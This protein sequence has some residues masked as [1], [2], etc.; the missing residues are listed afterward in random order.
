MGTRA[1]IIIREGRRKV[2]LWHHW[3]GEPWRLGYSLMGAA[4]T[5]NTQ[6]LSIEYL[7]TGI[8]NGELCC[9]TCRLDFELDEADEY[10]YEITRRRG[11]WKVTCYDWG[12]FFHNS[13]EDVP[14]TEYRKYWPTVEL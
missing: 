9:E 4:E 12:E 1:N 13:L 14:V 6:D 8:I 3:H 5:A 10:I 2:I 11:R 7:A